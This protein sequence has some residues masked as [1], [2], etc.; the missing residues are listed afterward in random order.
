MKV[1]VVGGGSTYTPELVDGI[2]RLKQ[3]FSVDDLVLVDPAE[4]RLA[5]VAGISQR[6]FAK[7]GYSGEITFTTDLDRAVSDAAVVLLQL[8]VGGQAARAVDESLPL[9]CGC[10]GQE[11]TGAGG[12]AKA[13]RTVPVILQIAERI[14]RLAAKDAWIID[15]TNPV[16]IV[17]RA[18]LDHGHRAVGLCNVAIG[19]QRAA[20]EL[21]GIEPARV[22]LD[23]V[24]LNHLTWTR[25][26]LVD[27]QDRL[28]ELL[29]SSAEEL[30]GRS[31]IPAELLRRLA[32]WPSYYLRYFYEH[33]QVVEQQRVKSSR[34]EDVAAIERQLLQIYADPAVDEKPAL[35]QQ[36]GG[37]YYSEAAVD[38]MASLLTD[39]GDVQVVNLRNDG[40]LPFLAD[41]AVIEVPARVGQQ[42]PVPVEAAPVDPLFA[43]LIAHVSAYEE[44]AL[45]AAVRGGRERV[46]RTLLA[47][48]LIGQHDLADKLTDLLIA[49]NRDHLQ[50][51]A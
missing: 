33:D 43:G 36:R 3:L 6:I 17:T 9:R 31:G 44:L 28:P 40:T 16:G 30:A 27:G 48:P 35:L 46:F 7:F 51:A 34:A 29:E 4:E 1:A 38:L 24:G 25:Q 13:L 11:T 12:L 37:A 10:V 23:H 19:N 39:R 20:A 2:A 45:D 21:L 47:H 15:F 18:L 50:W 32:V 41:Q 49:A 14:S 42:G 22:R 5:L 8:R 26:I